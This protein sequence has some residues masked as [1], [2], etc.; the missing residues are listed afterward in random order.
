MSIEGNTAVLNR[1]YISQTAQLSAAV[2]CGDAVRLKSFSFTVLPVL[3]MAKAL[4]ISV[5]AHEITDS[6]YTITVPIT[7][8]GEVFAEAC[9][10]LISASEKD[11]HKIKNVSIGTANL[12]DITNLSANIPYSEDYIYKYYVLANDYAVLKNNPPA[13][14]NPVFSMENGTLKASWDKPPDDYNAISYYKIFVDGIEVA[15]ISELSDVEN[16]VGNSYLFEG[17]DMANSHAVSIVACDHEGLESAQNISV[18]S[19]D[20]LI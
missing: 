2:I 8:S 6:I 11:A 12:T 20:S 3:Y 4:T 5:A 15:R 18:I 10:M 13:K 16:T 7:V 14:V 17:L 9:I 1:D 19:H